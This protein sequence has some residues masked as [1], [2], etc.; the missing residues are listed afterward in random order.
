MRPTAGC[1]RALLLALAGLLGCAAAAGARAEE[2][3][4]PAAPTIYKWVDANGI[5]HY[6]TDLGRVP[7]SVR[8]S[9]RELG[10]SP[11]SEGYAA[12]DAGDAAPAPE[13]ASPE[14]P[15]EWDVG[16]APPPAPAP[17]PARAPAAGADRWAETDRALDL[18]PD[19]RGGG[20][21][22]QTAAAEPSEG[23][24][25]M[26]AADR[27][28]QR[29]DLETRIA[30]LETEIRAD[31]EAMKG[32]LAVPSPDNPAEIAYDRSFRDVAERLPKRLA[33]LRSLQSERAQLDQQP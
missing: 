31:E 4:T 30:A 10:A 15:P 21:A 28:G 12:R 16:D 19:E 25:R 14:P 24:P 9:V 33:E 11:P 5:A 3:E 26:S 18:P 1:P 17:A 6:T 8:G 22:A 23:E 27:A 2:A 7:R 29:H 32:F 20:A 13:V